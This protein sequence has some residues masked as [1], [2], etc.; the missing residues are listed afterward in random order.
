MLMPARIMLSALTIALVVA[1]GNWAHGVVFTWTNAA[2]G[3][4][5]TNGNW[6]NAGDPDANDDTAILPNIAGAYTVSL[7]TP[8]TIEQLDITGSQPTLDL[9]SNLTVDPVPDLGTTSSNF[10]TIDINSSTLSIVTNTF[11]QS[12][13]I[14]A[15]GGTLRF[16]H[17]VASDGPGDVHTTVDWTVG[18]DITD[19]YT[20]FIPSGTRTTIN[21]SSTWNFLSGQTL[22][23]GTSVVGNGGCCNETSLDFDRDVTNSGTMQLGNQPGDHYVN[24]FFTV[25]ST[26]SRL[27]NNSDGVINMYPRSPSTY[28]FPWSDRRVEAELIN[29]GEVNVFTFRGFL[30]KAGAGVDHDNTGT[31]T[32]DNSIL[33][34]NPTP[35]LRE[36]PE[37]FVSGE[38]LTN[39]ASGTINGNGILDVTALTSGELTND[40]TLSPGLSAGILNVTG[41]VTN[42]STSVLEIELGGTVAGNIQDED[43]EFDQLNIS[44]TFAIDG[45]LLVTLIDGFENTITSA[46]TFTVATF[47]NS[48]GSFTNLNDD[49]RVVIADFLVGGQGAWFD[50]NI[51]PTSIVLSDFQL[52]PVPEPSSLALL[53]LGM[54]GLVGRARRNRN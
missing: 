40:G 6:D 18:S 16:G 31:I 22:Q 54:I 11:T 25:T 14:N 35:A 5:T 41:D 3:N 10:G 12:G 37:L 27:T 53:G 38:T 47:S 7:T 13:T 46:D 51:G 30:G 26:N 15:N 48:S 39:S 24:L 20:L 34:L 29:Q 52:I 36:I 23:Y 8:R 33:G 28:N 42:S 45:E 4:W 49:D 2:G 43:M 19:P 32:F 9:S 17:G 1:S 44:G 21:R 50:V